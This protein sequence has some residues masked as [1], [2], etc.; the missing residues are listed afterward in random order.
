[1]TELLSV[2]QDLLL[3]ILALTAGGITSA[4]VGW[5]AGNDPLDKDRTFKATL[6]AVIGGSIVWAMAGF[7]VMP[8][9]VGWAMG[10]TGESGIRR[11]KELMDSK[12][13]KG[14]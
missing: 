4:L 1:M 13:K 6:K 11:G 7:E 9:A 3:F 2:N 8:V 5:L 14:A 12:R 10:F